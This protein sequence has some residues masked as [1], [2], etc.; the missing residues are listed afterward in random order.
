[1]KNWK[2]LLATLMTLAMICT[3]L[4][5]TALAEA[6]PTEVIFYFL[7]E[8]LE[9]DKVVLAAINEKLKEKL[10]CYMT[11]TY[12]PFGEVNT[13]YP[14]LLAS[15]TRMDAIFSAYFTGYGTLA[16]KMPLWK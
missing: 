12:V 15:Q 13:T 4:P 2:R 14:L 10:N 11:V 6:Q 9:D 3:A 8:E 7:G 16:G 1:M 5:W